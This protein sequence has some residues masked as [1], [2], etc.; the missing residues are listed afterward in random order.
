[1]IFLKPYPNRTWWHRGK[2]YSRLE[3]IGDGVVHVVGLLVAIGLGSI[4]VVATGSQATLALSVYVAS[5]LLVLS[6]SLAFNLAP[7]APLKRVL[8]RFDQ[9]AIFLLIAGTYT[10]L[11]AMLGD[12]PTG[13]IMLI[14][15]WSSALIGIAL[16]L[17]VP[18]H[19]GRLALVL[20]LGIGWSGV[21]IF[22]SLASV[23]PASTLLLIVAG[24][25]AYSSGIV[26]HLWER[27]HFHN[28]IWHCFVVLGASIHLWAVLDC[29]VL[30][31]L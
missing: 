13:T 5:L 17:I 6:I 20:Y 29:M 23:L 28:V 19:F 25:V 3:L 4:L 2:P 24:G 12:T 7:V 26:F 21:L 15:V 18:Q 30:R 22:Q 8:A 16:K 11:L 1:M 31:R 14:A 9:A 10:P 27:L